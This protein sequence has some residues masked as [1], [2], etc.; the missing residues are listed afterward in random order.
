[1][2][3]I[4]NSI[5]QNGDFTTVYYEV[6]DN[7]LVINV[8]EKPSDY[9]T[10]SGNIN[11]EDLA[12]V[13]VGFQGSKIIN[14]T[15]VRYSVTGTVANEYGARGKAT[16]ELGKN[17]KVVIYTEFDYKRDIIE[18]QKYK[19]GYFNFENRKFKLGTGIG[20]EMYK[21]LLFSVGGGYQ[22]SDVTKHENHD[23]NVRKVFPY[24]EAKI[25]YDTRDSINFAT[26]G[27]HL[28]SNYTLANSKEAKFNSLSAGGEINIPI[29]EK[30]TI[31][32][33]AVYLTSYGDDIPETYRP[34]MGGIRTSDNSL[35]FAG[36]PA[37]K[38]RGNSIFVGSLKVQ[39]NLSKFLYLDTTYSRA[40]IS[41]RSYKFGH[42]EKESYKFGIGAK[43]LAIPLY[44]GFAKVPGE[45]WRYIIN[46][47]YSPE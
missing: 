31:T 36:M 4:V 23:E 33:K 3:K 21:N 1:M 11:N 45:S 39:Y 29:G 38:I 28:F 44:F 24:F 15:N 26:R 35:E 2:E 7:D 14:N 13:N 8:Q 17:S 46:F 27:V 41:N 34:K 25:D 42:D 16:M 43:T 30:I 47:G 6:K 40:N 18:N 19:N 37:D 20:F 12:T 10:L 22:V 5:Y 9:L 32:P